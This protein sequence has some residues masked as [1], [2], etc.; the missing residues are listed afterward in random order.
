MTWSYFPQVLKLLYIVL[1]AYIKSLAETKE[2]ETSSDQGTQR[3]ERVVTNYVNM[4]KQP[5]EVVASG[6]S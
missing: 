3:R 4:P 2:P 5:W 1:P 6:R